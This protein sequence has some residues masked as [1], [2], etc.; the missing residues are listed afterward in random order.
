METYNIYYVHE[1]RQG[2]MRS[3]CLAESIEYLL[4]HGCEIIAIRDVSTGKMSQVAT[5]VRRIENE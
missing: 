1:N 3:H 2:T 4:D 5:N